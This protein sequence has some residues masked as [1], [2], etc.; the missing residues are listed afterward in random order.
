MGLTSCCPQLAFGLA[1][2]VSNLSMR[3]DSMECY[4]LLNRQNHR[5]GFP[6]FIHSLFIESSSPFQHSRQIFSSLKS[7]AFFTT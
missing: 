3:Y 2:L 7:L 6:S 4:R 1:Y 5:V